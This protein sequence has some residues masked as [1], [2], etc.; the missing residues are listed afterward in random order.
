M[1]KLSLSGIQ[2]V[3]LLTGD[4]RKMSP[5]S[6]IKEAVEEA[7]KYFASISIEV[8]PL[9]VEEYEELYRAGVDGS[10]DL[11]VAGRGHPAWVLVETCAG[12]GPGQAAE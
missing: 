6:Y 5:V 11:V 10:A 8:Y 12:V 4:S 3:L 9:E 1:K 2:N 7:K